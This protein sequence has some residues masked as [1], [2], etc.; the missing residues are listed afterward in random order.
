MIVIVIVIVS[1][2]AGSSNSKPRTRAGAHKAAGLAW[3]KAASKKIRS[4]RKNGSSPRS[5]TDV[6]SV[7]GGV[8][9]SQEVGKLTRIIDFKEPSYITPLTKG[10]TS[11]GSHRKLP[12]E[13]LESYGEVPRTNT[14][15]P[16]TQRLPPTPPARSTPHV[17]YADPPPMSTLVESSLD[18]GMSGV[19]P[20]SAPQDRKRLG[21]SAPMSP[22]MSVAPYTPGS[23]G[24]SHVDAGSRPRRAAVPRPSP[25]R[26]VGCVGHAQLRVV[27]YGCQI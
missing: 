24:N 2:S 26:F 15:S 8:L 22:K 20:H 1:V 7:A 25:G 4:P 17:P 14:S 9:S 16:H 3:P 13:P 12:Q 5:R 21:A 23:A 6:A 10:P 19:R 18:P 27:A 11:I